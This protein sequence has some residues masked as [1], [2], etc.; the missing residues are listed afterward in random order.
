MDNYYQSKEWFEKRKQKL[1]GSNYSCSICMSG[2]N[3]HVH[4]RTYAHFKHEP[5]SDLIVLCK[6]CHEL[7]KGRFEKHQDRKYNFI[8]FDTT[9]EADKVIELLKHVEG[10]EIGLSGNEPTELFRLIRYTQFEAYSYENE[11]QYW[12]VEV[13]GTKST[14]CKSFSKALEFILERSNCAKN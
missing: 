12:I 10:I 3:L 6:T 7:V 9:K 1:I 8:N 4:H 5:L 14:I 2:Q 13:S 11:D